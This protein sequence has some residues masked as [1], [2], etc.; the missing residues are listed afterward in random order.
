[1]HKCKFFFSE[2]NAHLS[3]HNNLKPQLRDLHLIYFLNA[4]NFSRSS[5]SPQCFVIFLCLLL[6]FFAQISRSTQRV[7]LFQFFFVQ[8][9]KARVSRNT[10]LTNKKIKSSF[11]F[12]C[13]S[14]ATTYL[15]LVLFVLG[16]ELSFSGAVCAL[17]M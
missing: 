12:A 6:Q 3:S 2:S 17:A 15:F 14:A 9:K 5:T 7:F 8:H 1:M 4:A 13:L 11:Y 16:R 10:Q